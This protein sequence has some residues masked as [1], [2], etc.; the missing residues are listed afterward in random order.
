MGTKLACVRRSNLPG[1]G[2]ACSSYTLRLPEVTSL[3]PNIYMLPLSTMGARLGAWCTAVH[4]DCLAV[5]CRVRSQALRA[6]PCTWMC[7]TF[8]G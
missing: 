6:P 2:S 8:T 5:D 3:S 4:S 1:L 7:P